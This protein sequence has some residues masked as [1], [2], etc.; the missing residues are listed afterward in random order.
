MQGSGL[1]EKKVKK[2]LFKESLHFVKNL[3]SK[4]TS[5]EEQEEGVHQTQLQREQ[6]LPEKSPSDEHPSSSEAI[7]R[8]Q[9]K[10]STSRSS[11]HNNTEPRFIKLSSGAVVDRPSKARLPHY[12]APTPPSAVQQ[13]TAVPPNANGYGYGTTIT[14]TTGQSSWTT[15]FRSP[16]ATASSLTQQETRKLPGEIDM[17]QI[18]YEALLKEARM[19]REDLE[20]EYNR[21]RGSKEQLETQI[22][23]TKIKIA[24]AQSNKPSD[25]I[26]DDIIV[27]LSQELTELEKKVSEIEARMNPLDH[28][29]SDIQSVEGFIKDRELDSQQ[30]SMLFET[31]MKKMFDDLTLGAH[32]STTTGGGEASNGVN[33]MPKIVHDELQEK[34]NESKQGQD[35]IAFYPEEED[36]SGKF[37]SPESRELAIR[38]ERLASEKYQRFSRKF[39]QVVEFSH[40]RTKSQYHRS[41]A[42]RF[43]PIDRGDALKAPS[44]SSQRMREDDGDSNVSKSVFSDK[45]TKSNALHSIDGCLWLGYDLQKPQKLTGSLAPS[46]RAESVADLQ[47]L[48]HYPGINLDSSFSGESKLQKS[49]TPGTPLDLG[50]PPLAPAKPSGEDKEQSE[51]TKTDPLAEA[52]MNV[53]L[54]KPPP[55]PLASDRPVVSDNDRKLEI[56]PMN[57]DD[58]DLGAL[59]LAVAADSQ[60]NIKEKI[61]T[62]AETQ[63][64]EN[65]I[66]T[67][68]KI[69]AKNQTESEVKKEGVKKEEAKKAEIKKE[70][71]RAAKPP[72]PP[73]KK[74]PPPPPPPPPGKK[75]PGA[76]GGPPPP[77]GG[78]KKAGDG[79]T[80]AP[81]V[82][83]MFQEMRKALLGSATKTSGGGKKLGGGT[84]DPGALMDE[85]SKNSKYAAQ[86]QADIEKYGDMIPQLITEVSTFEAKTMLDMIEFVKRVDSVLSELSDET[87]V[88]KQF[89]W[90]QRYYTMMEAKGLYEE[91]EKMKRTFSPWKK[92]EN[93]ATAELQIIQKFMD[94]SK[95]RVD[96]I[97]R[98]KDAD[99]KKFKDNKIPWNGKIF[100]EVKIAS[101]SP[102]IVYMEVVLEEVKSLM[103]SVPAEEGP[104]RKKALDKSLEHLRGAITFAFKVHQFAGG[105]TEAC[106]LKFAEISVK[107]RE[108][109]NEIGGVVTS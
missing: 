40:K 18:S 91:L 7:N 67:D 102:L 109:R 3:R 57:L 65:E 104:V 72:P 78:R 97:L 86:V 51:D 76:K 95:T 46:D 79:L 64:T 29:I 63:T 83:A 42:F 75:K 14:T 36:F 30:A 106:S 25:R 47:A 28:T 24:E 93:K 96:V 16:T 55:P 98:T 50:K 34:L 45:T 20:I 31:I 37:S 89:D 26:Y 8:R 9:T 103:S 58:V 84:A 71:L 59:A 53:K 44:V 60:H 49:N 38:K 33:I 12:D 11:N 17:D 107:T 10:A 48:E 100:T 1:K 56:P 81:E 68:A 22:T 5:V 21:N 19:L 73:P 85:L 61:K 108:I 105:F 15:E 43:D 77:P 2:S 62:D 82:I 69:E 90:P 87:A 54:K 99:E 70:D 39:D 4:K 94:K 6:L 74:A 52:L 23:D 66:K 88:L 92:T 32:A 27:Q 41:I 13:W 80:R 101:L 35:W